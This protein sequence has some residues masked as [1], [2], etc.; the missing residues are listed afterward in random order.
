[1]KDKLKYQ[2]DTAE[3]AGTGVDLR[4]RWRACLERIRIRIRSILSGSASLILLWLIAIFKAPYNYVATDSDFKNFF[5]KLAAADL[6]Q[7]CWILTIIFVVSKIY[8]LL[9]PTVSD[10]NA[11]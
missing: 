6:I 11:N 2:P 3:A 9:K 4:V 7:L 1:M 5:L 8:L 10:K